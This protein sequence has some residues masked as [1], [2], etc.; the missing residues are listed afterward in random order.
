LGRDSYE[1]ATIL[2]EKRRLAMVKMIS[3]AGQRLVRFATIF[4]GERE[5]RSADRC[6][7]GALIGSK[8]LKPTAGYGKKE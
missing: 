2:K 4:F 3:Q 5:G 1:G 6:G 8:M 7:M